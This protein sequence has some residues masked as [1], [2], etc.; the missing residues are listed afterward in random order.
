[1]ARPSGTNIKEKN[2]LAKETINSIVLGAVNEDDSIK[3]ITTTIRLPKK[4]KDEI[5]KLAKEKGIT[6]SAFI[7][8]AI[9]D[10][11]KK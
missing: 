1:M 8:M 5:N 7:K 10:A 6:S 4:M 9:S 11:I 3:T 2:N